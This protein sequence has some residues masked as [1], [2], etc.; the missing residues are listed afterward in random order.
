M[1]TTTDNDTNDD[2]ADDGDDDGNIPMCNFQNGFSNAKVNVCVCVCIYH[3]TKSTPEISFQS[4]ERAVI[5][6]ARYHS[7][8][9]KGSR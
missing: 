9:Q 7:N 1:K 3:A 8:A 5:V 2:D 4:H 6:L